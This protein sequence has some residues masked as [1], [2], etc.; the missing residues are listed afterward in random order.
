VVGGSHD[1][2]VERYAVCVDTV[3]E[4]VYSG[5]PLYRLS[6]LFGD[7]LDCRGRYGSSYTMGPWIPPPKSKGLSNSAWTCEKVEGF[8]G[9]WKR[10]NFHQNR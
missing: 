7:S 10:S 5:I 1:S 9:S 8:V 4:F 2:W 3:K 6:L